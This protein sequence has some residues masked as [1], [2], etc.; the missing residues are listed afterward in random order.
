M[1]PANQVGCKNR[2]QLNRGEEGGLAVMTAIAPLSPDAIIIL[3][4]NLDAVLLA[5]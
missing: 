2:R 4:G 3:D 5:G 1:A